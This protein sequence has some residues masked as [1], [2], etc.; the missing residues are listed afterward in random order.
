M[1]IFLPFKLIYVN[2]HKSLALEVSVVSRMV[3]FKS[4]SESNNG[5]GCCWTMILQVGKP[6]GR[7]LG[8]P[9]AAIAAFEATSNWME[10]KRSGK[11]LADSMGADGRFSFWFSFRLSLWFSLW[12]SLC[13][14]RP[15]AYSMKEPEVGGSISLG[16]RR[17]VII[18][19]RQHR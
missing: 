11:P 13:L 14:R 9:A 2:I 12:F 7:L 1:Y 3:N 18:A 16:R 8:L 17:G 6:Y 15:L 5:S 4:S 10:S 19:R